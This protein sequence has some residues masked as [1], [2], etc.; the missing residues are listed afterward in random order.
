MQNPPGDPAGWKK[1]TFSATSF[2]S[3]G[4]R[5]G[6]GYREGQEWPWLWWVCLNLEAFCFA[7]P[8]RRGKGTGE[9]PWERSGLE[10]MRLALYG[11]LGRRLKRNGGEVSSIGCGP[12]LINTLTFR[13]TCGIAGCLGGGW[14]LAGKSRKRGTGANIGVL[15]NFFKVHK[16]SMYISSSFERRHT[17]SS[18]AF[19]GS[20]NPTLG[21]VLHLLILP[22]SRRDPSGDQLP[23]GANSY[24]GCSV[25]W[26]GTLGLD[27]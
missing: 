1:I 17:Q 10:S 4:E 6:C 18:F 13:M 8:S 2:L 11:N 12:G 5:S 23:E 20:A 25:Y 27:T 7:Y 14:G 24:T 22:L 3:L 21:P 19:W 15:A 26:Y 16:P 9:A